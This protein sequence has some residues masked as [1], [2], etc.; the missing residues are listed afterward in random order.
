MLRFLPPLPYIVQ[1]VT[2]SLR[3][4]IQQLLEYLSDILRIAYFMWS[5]DADLSGC[6]EHTYVHTHM[7]KNLLTYIYTYLDI[8][9]QTLLHI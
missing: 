3:E 1:I 9:T 8:Y 4:N 7:H 5:C 6:L 2:K